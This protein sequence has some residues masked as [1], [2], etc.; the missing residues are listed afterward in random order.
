MRPLKALISKNTI[1]R[2]H[3][4]FSIEDFI[5]DPNFNDLKAG[6]IVYT[7]D[8]EIPKMYIVANA[9]DLPEMFDNISIRN[10]YVKLILL[11]YA[12]TALGYTYWDADSFKEKFPYNKNWDEVKIEKIWNSE[13]DLKTIKSKDDFKALYDKICEQ[14]NLS[15]QI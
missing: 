7:L 12:T 11:R 15:V 2:A 4:P 14:L 3:A 1:H 8:G 9:K 5:K 10:R 6:N 13:V